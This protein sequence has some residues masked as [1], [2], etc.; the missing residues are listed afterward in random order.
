MLAASISRQRAGR[1]VDMA[2]S[3]EGTIAIAVGL[4]GVAGGGAVWVAP[5]ETEI[6]WAMIATAVAG[7]IALAF[8]HFREKLARLWAPSARL[9]VIALY[10]IV[11][12]GL[13]FAGSAVV[14]FWPRAAA[15]DQ[16]LALARLAELG[17][18]VKPVANGTDFEIA[19]RALPPM[20]ESA[21]AFRQLTHPFRLVLQRVPGLVGLHYLNT[22]E[23]CTEID[24]SAGE[25]TDI[26]ELSGFVHLH[27]LAVTQLP[28]NGLGT[29]DATVLA[30]LSDLR[31][32]VLGS[33]RI[34]DVQFASTLTRLTTF[35]IEQ[36]LVYDISPI[37]GL[38][39]LESVD[40]RGTR[41]S[42]LR[43]LSEAHHLKDLMISGEQVPGLVSLAHL[44]NIT[45]LSIIEQHPFDLTSV[46][47]MT[48]L[49]RLWI[50]CGPNLLDVA[51][52]SKLSALSDL[53]ITG[54][55][56]GAFVPVSHI[57]VIGEL[58]ELHNLTLGNLLISDLSFVS[59]LQH[60]EKLS[61]A[62]IPIQSIAPVASIKLLRKMS[63]IDIQVVDISPLLELPELAAL[64]M[65]R[66]PARADVIRELAQRGVKTEP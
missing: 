14:Y 44:H 36:T 51:A 47:V 21:A 35:N 22:I 64:S 54:I 56:I 10:G 49:T 16:G 53:T 55:G 27:K 66:V 9:K 59:G 6:G 31:E 63:M 26:S 1:I 43:P 61:I 25:F 57:E 4:I 7:G 60:L 28:L 33:T 50:W 34:R 42:D 23:N 8:Y 15:P 32:L 46:G 3:A 37:S 58:T 12:F 2:I 38:I 20:Q 29:V 18:T 45:S 11:V 17:W 48:T 62:Q 39:Q 30:S 24:I 52:L 40:I 5:S 13:G 65:I 41:I 19:D